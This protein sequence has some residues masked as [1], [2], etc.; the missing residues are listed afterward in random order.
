METLARRRALGRP[1]TYRIVVPTYRRPGDLE[2]FLIGI[3]SQL[4]RHP[5]VRL[6]VVNDGSHDDAYQAA[7]APYGHLIDYRIEP[8]NRGVQ[9]ARHAGCADAQE[10]ILVFTDDDCRPDR[11][12]IDWLMALV[13]M[14]P[15]V[16]MFCGATWPITQDDPGDLE[17]FLQ[18]TGRY[19]MPVGKP[20]RLLVAPHANFACSRELYERVGGLDMRF[21]VA[22]DWNLT[23]RM[24]R[25]GA[26]Y[27]IASDWI[28]RHG[29]G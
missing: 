2:K 6:V 1:L 21:R 18:F 22:E 16:E 28:T 5:N 17:R 19:P 8:E 29:E 11:H 3:E 13:E 15:S 4:I 9:Y 25:A 26:V 10:D 23:Q 24:L 7:V 20:P 27:K 12:W 14:H